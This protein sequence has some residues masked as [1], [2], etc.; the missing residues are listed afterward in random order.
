[1]YKINFCGKYLFNDAFKAF[2][3]SIVHSSFLSLKKL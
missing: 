3:C 2:E 1:M